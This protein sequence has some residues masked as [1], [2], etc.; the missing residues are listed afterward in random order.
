MQASCPWLGVNTLGGLS[1]LLDRLAVRRKRA[2]TYLHSPDADYAAKVAYLEACRA[3]A[4][5]HPEAILFV[6]LDEFGFERQPTLAQD[7]EARGRRAPLA[8]LSYRSNTRCRGLG[9]LNAATGQV[10]YGQYSHIT[11][12]RLSAFYAQLRADYPHADRIY[13]AQDNW[14]VHVHPTVLARLEPQLSPFWPHVPDNWPR[15]A[16]AAA[17]HE[18]L[19]IQLVFLPT[20]APWLNPI[21][22]LWR[23]VRQQVLHLHRLSDDW[24]TLK[25]RVLDFMRAFAQGS[26]LLLRYVGLLPY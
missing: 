20:Y 6:Y 26:E 7:Y 23:W 13:V 18:A 15:Q 3:A 12:T 19:P 8:R 4:Q 22:K 21:E 17:V 16:P 10:T 24:L 2:R 5:A 14:P 1:Q 9:G 25:Q 11:A